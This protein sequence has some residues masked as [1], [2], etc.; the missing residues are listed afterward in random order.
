MPEN[1]YRHILMQHSR[2]LCTC[3]LLPEDRY[4]T[5]RNPRCGDELKIAAEVAN[6]NIDDIRY[7][8]K[9]CAIA[10]ASLSILMTK[11]KKQTVESAKAFIDR[12]LSAM[13]DSALSPEE[14][15]DLKA[16]LAVRQHPSRIRCVTLAWVALRS[17]LSDGKTVTT[18]N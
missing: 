17:A 9:A 14:D 18:E 15:D 8:I 5:G 10:T 6:G 11:T 13:D 4:V 3:T 1:L 16:L 7:E 2:D 12:F